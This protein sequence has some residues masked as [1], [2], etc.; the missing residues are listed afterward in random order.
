MP[1]AEGVF[2][3][4]VARVRALF[5]GDWRTGAGQRFR[6]GTEAISVLAE[7]VTLASEELLVEGIELGRRKLTG[8]ASQEDALAEKNYAEAGRAIVETEEKKIEA[9]L[10]RRAF[11]SEVSRKHA[12]ARKANAE[13]SLAETKALDAQFD[14]MNKLRAAGMALH[15]DERGNLSVLPSETAPQPDSSSRQTLL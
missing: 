2:T 15:R 9:E 11:E 13:A 10:K 3:R 4:L 5:P 6:E 7:D 12:E 8:L 1:E 14:L